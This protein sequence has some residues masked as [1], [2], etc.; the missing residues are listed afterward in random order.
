[1]YLKR[2]KELREDSDKKQ[3]EIAEIL[4]IPVGTVKSRL[5]LAKKELA[6][7]IEEYEK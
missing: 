2:L 1:M 5:N 7:I 4:H 6:A 3:S